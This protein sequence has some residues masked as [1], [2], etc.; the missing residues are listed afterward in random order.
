MNTDKQLLQL[1]DI[2]AYRIMILEFLMYKGFTLQIKDRTKR[3]RTYKF[4]TRREY[5]T[6]YIYKAFEYDNTVSDMEKILEDEIKEADK[7]TFNHKK[8]KVT[9]IK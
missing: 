3:R 4:D 5:F 7:I 2:I 9:I 8:R 6:Y 1:A